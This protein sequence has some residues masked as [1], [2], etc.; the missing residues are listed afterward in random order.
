MVYTKKLFVQ[1]TSID[2]VTDSLIYHSL[3][4]NLPKSFIKIYK[5]EELI[6]GDI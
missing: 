1:I 2:K 5:S 6:I 4:K 3:K